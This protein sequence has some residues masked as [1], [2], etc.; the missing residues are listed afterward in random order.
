MGTELYNNITG[1]IR[2]SPSTRA[3]REKMWQD[4]HT[5]V[6]FLE[7]RSLWENITH[8]KFPKHMLFSFYV[9]VHIFETYLKN[10]FPATLPNS[11]IPAS[12]KLSDDEENVL[13]Y[14]GGY[15]IRS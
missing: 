14:V 12:Q 13:Q 9:T 3:V 4:L 8:Q 2:K 10:R 7:H 5:F 6:T 11:D 15:I 1:I